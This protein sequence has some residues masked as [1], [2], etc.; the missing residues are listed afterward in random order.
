MILN[1]FTNYTL[2]IVSRALFGCRTFCHGSFSK[3]KWGAKR[4]MGL[5]KGIWGTERQMWH[6]KGK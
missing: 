5:A 3:K 2:G 1:S 6:H 4:Q